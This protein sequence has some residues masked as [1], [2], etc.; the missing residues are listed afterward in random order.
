MRRIIHPILFDDILP[1]S[2]QN[3]QKFCGI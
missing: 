3:G 2:L 1:Q